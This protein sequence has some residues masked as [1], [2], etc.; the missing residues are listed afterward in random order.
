M[1]THLVHFVEERAKAVGLVVASPIGM[2]PVDMLSRLRSNAVRRPSGFWDAYNDYWRIYYLENWK[3]PRRP[4]ISRWYQENSSTTWP[5]DD[6]PSLE[7]VFEHGK[8]LRITEDMRKSLNAYSLRKRPGQGAPG[9]LP[10]S[11]DAEGDLSPTD[12]LDTEKDNTSDDVPHP[13]VVKKRPAPSTSPRSKRRR[14]CEDK[15]YTDGGSCTVYDDTTCRNIVAP[16]AEALD[17]GNM[18]R[19]GIR[20]PLPVPAAGL[21]VAEGASEPTSAATTSAT[22]SPRPTIPTSDRDLVA[23]QST[24]GGGQLGSSAA[25][26]KL[27]MQGHHEGVSSLPADAAAHPSETTCAQ[28]EPSPLGPCAHGTSL[29]VASGTDKSLVSTTTCQRTAPLSPARRPVTRSSDINGGGLAPL[30]LLDTNAGVA[31]R[32][33]SSSSCSSAAYGSGWAHGAENTLQLPKEICT[34]SGVSG[35]S[36]GKADKQQLVACVLGVRKPA[37]QQHQGQSQDKKRTLLHKD[38][39]KHGSQGSLAEH[40]HQHCSSENE[41][42][43][44]PPRPQRQC[45]ALRPVQLS[46]APAAQIVAEL[47]PLNVR[48]PQYATITDMSGPTAQTGEIAALMLPQTSQMSTQSWPVLPAHS[49]PRLLGASTVEG[50]LQSTIVG[51]FLSQAIVGQ[52][53]PMSL[54]GLAA[55]DIQ[56]QYGVRPLEESTSTQLSVDKHSRT[57]GAGGALCGPAEASSSGNSMY[58]SSLGLGA[59]MRGTATQ[60][61]YGGYGSF[62]G[63]D[64][65]PDVSC[66]IGTSGQPS[67]QYQHQVCDGL[68]ASERPQYGI[69]VAEQ[70]LRP[71]NVSSYYHYGPAALTC[72]DL[73]QSFRYPLG[74]P[75]LPLSQPSPHQLTYHQVRIAQETSNFLSPSADLYP[76]GTQQQHLQQHQ[77]A[78]ASTGNQYAVPLVPSLQAAGYRQTS[79]STSG[80]ENLAVQPN[81]L[82]GVCISVPASP[83]AAVSDSSVDHSGTQVPPRQLADQKA[84]Y[85]SA[86]YRP[87]HRDYEALQDDELENYYKSIISN[88]DPE[89]TTPEAGDLMYA[90][91]AYSEQPLLGPSAEWADG[92]M[93][94][95]WLLDGLDGID[96]VT[97][98]VAAAWADVPGD[99]GDE[100]LQGVADAFGVDQLQKHFGTVPSPP[101]LLDVAGCC[102]G[103]TICARYLPYAT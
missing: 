32:F 86:Y 102:V 14:L 44:R 91:G 21:K 82:P 67:Y 90:T 93:D 64:Y 62:Y 94:T 79:S 13:R 73:P 63:T 18:K 11:R 39:M 16:K 59:D 68:A 43:S 4:E 70:S 33:S 76:H 99:M 75:V 2:A 65:S 88:P 25:D 27:V 54:D 53:R 57:C 10:G 12:R 101:Q 15:S 30:G 77:R 29:P 69:T 60:S 48:P 40:Q 78:I 100:S 42:P 26:G 74:A 45:L 17:A 19:D 38:A 81:S 20:Q 1:R 9:L 97:A 61:V 83:T 28:N 46:T 96:D 103:G 87:A 24:S 95:T 50:A 89:V 51:S 6:R 56:F 37:Q 47:G 41:L 72:P 8:G 34:D 66:G 49:F 31:S 7:D 52:S 58:T 3:K 92:V 22:I 80:G 5:D 35:S 85:L 55:H 23:T 98:D 36:G 71:W 84:L